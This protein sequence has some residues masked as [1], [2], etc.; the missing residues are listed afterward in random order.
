MFQPR[1]TSCL[2]GA[3]CLVSAIPAWPARGNAQ[4][5]PQRSYV[6][7]VRPRYAQPR[8]PTNS[9]HPEGRIR[10]NHV[11]AKWRNVLEDLS[12]SMNVALVMPDEPP[13][14]Y[15][16]FDR[17]L[18]THTEAIRIL[19]R[20]LE[21]LG[22]RLVLRGEYLLVLELDAGRPE[23]KRPIVHTSS[24][25]TA[26]TSRRRSSVV[27]G[28]GAEAARAATLA[29]ARS[30][31]PMR[32][33]PPTHED[34]SR[35]FPVRQAGFL[36]ETTRAGNDQKLRLAMKYQRADLVAERLFEAC[37]DWATPTS[38]R[39]EPFTF[40]VDIQSAEPRQ[41]AGQG[42]GMD[43]VTS[44]LQFSVVTDAPSNELVL[45]TSPPLA[46]AITHL[47]AS[48]DTRNVRLGA[49]ERLI[50]GVDDAAS[51]ARKVQTPLNTLRLHQR[52]QRIAARQLPDQTDTSPVAPKQKPPNSLQ[53]IE[54]LTGDVTVDVIEDLGVLILRGDSDDVDAV[55]NLIGEI[56]KLGIGAGLEI[57]LLMLSFINSES[58]TELLSGV[59]EPPK[60]RPSGSSVSITP[61]RSPNAILIVAP[62]TLMPVVLELADKLDQPGDPAS[63]FRVFALQQAVATQVLDLLEDFYEPKGGLGARIKAVVDIRTNSLIVQGAPRDLDE[64]AALIQRIDHDESR[65]VS[66]M[67]IFPLRNAA[68][69]ELVEVINT[70]LR[71][72]LSDPQNVP[73]T[74][75]GIGAAP[76]STS[77]DRSGVPNRRATAAK[78]VVL[79]FLAADGVNQERLRSGIL[80]DIR[81][82]ADPRTNSLVVTAPAQ[83]MPLMAELIR[84][85]DTPTSMVAEIKVF[86]L[87]NADATA[88]GRLLETL[89]SS[90]SQQQR[91]GVQIAGAED[92]SSSLIP[93]KFSVDVRTNSILATGGAEALRVA[94]AI[95]L[96][97]DQSDLRQRRSVVYRLRNSP[98]RDVA[99]AINQFLESQRDLSQVDPN[100]VS[101]VEQV[102]REVIVVPELV[103][104]SLLI[105]STPRHYDEIMELTHQLDQPPPQ[106]IIQALLVEVVLGSDDEFG[107]ELGVQDPVLFDRSAI[108]DIVTVT[109]TVFD[110]VTGLPVS[111]TERIVS[112][113]AQP[114]FSF[115]NQPL[116]NNPSVNTSAVGSQGLSNFSL[117]RV[118]GDLGYGG[119]VL[120]AGS[121]SVNVLVRALAARRKINVLSR[122][123]IRTLDNQL[124]T[125]QVGQQV[126]IVDGVAVSGTGSANP[127]VRQDQAG[128]ILSVTPR[129]SP[130]EV[131]VMEVAAEKS[132]FTGQGVPLFTDANNG[133]VIESPIKDVIKA[134]TTV[135]IPNGQTVVLG[136]MI[137]TLDDVTER[138]VP[139]FGDLPVLGHAFR[140][141]SSTSRRTELL[142]FL[143]PRVVHSS[144]DSEV[145]KQ[146]EAARLHYV[147]SA[148]EEV[149]G[150]L[151]G[152]PEEPGFPSSEFPPVLR[153]VPVE[154]SELVLPIPADQSPL[155]LPD[156]T[157][158]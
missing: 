11:Q 59:F 119:L 96:R 140:Y 7:E 24:P 87:A 97:L 95:L 121:E 47:V 9:P 122:P 79:Q 4:L 1:I 117:G 85:L 154:D 77:G 152:V 37:R 82:S 74:P 30:N 62:A 6:T 25:Q 102:E 158:P 141:D 51:V 5:L 68:A 17:T 34:R 12:K 76:S 45:E 127:V 129:I 126:P 15:S 138:K 134:S 26:Q 91:L 39:N 142:I 36:S 83:S 56:Q 10:L 13:G 75:A 35:Q 14:Y 53:T 70:A 115:N 144:V 136:G 16:R 69:E 19:N 137:T 111:S 84:Q 109:D 48:F 2:L 100:L 150:P 89:F 49:S 58:L 42:G 40:R 139:W 8:A 46:D 52:T 103:S 57:H 128:I 29:P 33:L 44:A 157:Q 88:M 112:Q 55:A 22:M 120:S 50:A 81:V 133:N 145:I 43:T 32:R 31:S 61:L 131:I 28:S 114:G 54:Q 130:E 20:E 86:T 104:N 73:G 23:Y 147:E 125:I 143:T 67:R 156:P 151:F 99:D 90:P 155:M 71:S 65:A 38:Q 118:N 18:H 146:V 21:P 132:Q 108:S 41:G 148:A 110:A 80:S 116:G 63:V 149:H 98:A 78:S 60:T 124:A 105:S 135:S 94:E 153:D 64:V 93:M 123:Q 101:A 92:A 3:V 72:A 66:Q 27:G 106:V 113:A 107:V